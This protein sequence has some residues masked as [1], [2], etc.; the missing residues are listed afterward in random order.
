LCFQKE[1]ILFSEFERIFSDLFS[2]RS[3]TYKNI[4]ERLAEGACELKDIYQHLGVEKSGVISTYMDDLVTAGFMSHDF[5]W[6]V[7]TGQDSKSSRF[8]LKDN[9]LRFYLKY[10]DPNKK[11]IERRT[12]KLLPQWQSVMGLQF[13][14][15]VL[16]NRKAIYQLLEI[17]PSD[18]IND[19]P[20]FQRKT[21]G[22]PGCQIDYMIQDK[23]GSCYLCEIKFSGRE[24]TTTVIEEM[25]QKME[26]LKVPKHIS[27]RPV[28][29]HV[30][31]VDEQIIESGFFSSIINFNDLL[32]P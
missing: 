7:K 22:Q 23:F 11:K 15:L 1:G 18:I 9:Y 17:D 28:L 3:T 5:T 21:K 8:R 12:L 24:I 31:G 6:S 27:L 19:N 29:I 20:F 25:K 13:E 4:V 30:N 26:R 14:N 32:C 2:T 10:I 16:N